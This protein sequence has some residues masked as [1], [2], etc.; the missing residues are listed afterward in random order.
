MSLMFG[1]PKGKIQMGSRRMT[2]QA[3]RYHLE[4]KLSGR[5]TFPLI[6]G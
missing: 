2:G 3:N 6:K 4:I 5:E 1:L